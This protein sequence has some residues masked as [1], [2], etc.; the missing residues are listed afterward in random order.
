MAAT[1]TGTPIA[2]TSGNITVPSDCTAIYLFWSYFSGS[3]QGGIGSES[4]G[5]VPANSK[6]VKAGNTYYMSGGVAVWY[7]PPTG[8]QSV[9]ITWSPVV[10]YD[11]GPTA[12][13]VFVKD[14]DTTGFRD[15]EASYGEV[16][17]SVTIDSASTDLV[18]KAASAYDASMPPAG[19]GWTSRQTQ[20]KVLETRVSTADSPGAATTTANSEMTGIYTVIVAVS[21]KAATAA[22]SLLP[23]SFAA[24]SAYFLVR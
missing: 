17:Q 21:I 9:S 22:A 5:G 20:N 23:R 2:W 10:D 18:I 1:L 6:S 4:I 12:I 7:N 8:S 19:T 24:Q 13:F 16:G 11:I 14:G 3:G 15:A